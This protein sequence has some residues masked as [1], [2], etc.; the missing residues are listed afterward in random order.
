[1]K[2]PNQPVK[3]DD[4]LA[5]LI[6]APSDNSPAWFKCADKIVAFLTSSVQNI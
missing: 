3:S 4:H 6:P 2:K 5:V 1:M